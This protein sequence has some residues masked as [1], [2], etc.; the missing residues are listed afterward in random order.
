ME[1]YR[2]LYEDALERARKAYNHS[3]EEGWNCDKGIYEAIFPQL[4]ESEDERIRK[5]L[6]KFFS[7]I[8]V[9]E[10]EFNKWSNCDVKKWIAWLEKQG[11][12]KWSDKDEEMLKEIISVLEGNNVHTT[13][14]L[15]EYANWLKS[16]KPQN[17]WKPTKEQLEEMSYAIYRADCYGSEENVNILQSL[18]D[19]LKKL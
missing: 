15:Y 9:C 12:R 13:K 4:K 10:S 2:K 11:E 7:E 3:I 8:S 16:I 19:Q 6:I 5:E 17:H 14:M 1:D 18:Y